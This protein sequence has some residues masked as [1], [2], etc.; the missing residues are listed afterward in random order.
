[1]DIELKKA[2]KKSQVALQAAYPKERSSFKTLLL[3]NPNYFGNLVK[4]PF[5]SVLAISSNT[6]Y[7]ELICVGYHPQQRRLE[8]I[9]YIYQPTGY[10]TDICGPGSPEYVRFYLSF[11]NGVTW[12]DQ[13]M[14]SFQAFNIAQGTE[15]S[16]RLEYAVS[17][18][19]KPPAKFCLFNNHL[20][21][22]RAILSWNNPPPPNQP[23]WHPIWGNVCDVTIQIEPLH[24]IFPLEIFEIA[25]I[26]IPPVLSEV[27]DLEAPI[28]T[29]VKSLSVAELSDLYK[30]KGVPLHRFAYKELENFVSA[31][32][33]L[34]TDAF[35]ELL[36]S[37]NFDL[38]LGEILVPKTDGDV[39]Y[40][41]LKCVGLDPNSPDTLVGVIQIKK[42]SGYSGGP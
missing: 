39:S 27:F 13:G 26:K 16:K 21:R 30:D 29:K 23:N 5:K 7:E 4:S 22:A 33:K 9:V 32:T 28:Q 1:M 31:K 11:D 14:T 37:V 35:A 17:L 25:N 2:V 24:L 10:G 3:A 40:E 42:S 19:V 18:D 15:G 41:E 12:Q 38:D 34:T 6:Y 36:P 8:G 20:I